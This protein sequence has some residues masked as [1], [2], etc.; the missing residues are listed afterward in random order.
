MRSHSALYVD[1]GYLLSSAATRLTGSSLRRGIE[2]NY[3]ALISALTEVVQRDSGLPLLRVYWYDAA[4]DGKATPVQEGIALLPNV[5][6]R[7]GRIGVDGEQKG[8]DLRIGLGLVGHSRAGR[9]DAMYLLS[10]DDDLTEAVEEA[11]AQGVQ[12][13]V[14]AVPSS[15]MRPHGVSRHLLYSADG[16]DLIDPAV[17][18]RTV[19]STPAPVTA[20]PVKTTTDE[21]SMD[22]APIDEVA[23]SRPSPAGVARLVP[24]LATKTAVPHEGATQVQSV[25]RNPMELAE[26][27]TSVARKTYSAWAATASAEQ[28]NELRAGRPAIPRDLDRALLV[29]LSGVLGEF[30]LSDS[31]RFGVRAKFWEAVNNA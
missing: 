13:T 26:S 8:V 12:V 3:T 17:L 30:E 16:L 18:D 23:P 14:L 5:K 7:L 28:L 11:Q 10:G 6:L 1:A 27:M 24:P 15:S 4:R 25:S 22:S 31:M 19:T 9:I 2:V 20:P 29:D 21:P